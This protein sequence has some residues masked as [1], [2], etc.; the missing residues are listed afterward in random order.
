MENPDRYGFN[1]KREDLFKPLEYETV[2]VTGSVENWSDFAA[3][4]G[5]NFK[6]I[7]IYNQWIRSNK[8]ENKQRKIYTVQIPK[9]GFREN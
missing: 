3:L 8:L 6:M 4:H 5:T 2:K 7:K 1:L 9:K